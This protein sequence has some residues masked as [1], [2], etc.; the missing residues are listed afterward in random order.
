MNRLIRIVSK[1]LLKILVNIFCLFNF[2]NTSIWF[3]DQCTFRKCWVVISENASGK[4]FGWLKKT[5]VLPSK[6]WNCQYMNSPPDK[7]SRK[8][9]ISI[10]DFFKGEKTA[11]KPCFRHNNNGCFALS[12]H[13]HY[14][15]DCQC[16]M[17]GLGE[18]WY[19]SG[20]HSRGSAAVCPSLSK[21]NCP[22]LLIVH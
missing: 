7:L 12:F 6:K 5:V 16:A 11:V 21:A 19:C 15:I 18:Y 10:T 3:R 2:K 22:N 13:L 9:L 1:D 4:S 20:Q 8:K 14:R 17:H